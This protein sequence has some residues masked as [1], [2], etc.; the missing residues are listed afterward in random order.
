[1]NLAIFNE[2]KNIHSIRNPRY[3]PPLIRA[4]LQKARHGC[5][6][7]LGQAGMSTILDRWKLKVRYTKGGGRVRIYVGM[8]LGNAQIDWATFIKVLPLET[9]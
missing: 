2:E 8:G 6:P 5:F 1:M 4:H 9:Y 7:T 3:R